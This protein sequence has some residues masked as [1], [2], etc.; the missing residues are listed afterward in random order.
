M[1]RMFLIVLATGVGLALTGLFYLGA[2]PPHP[3]ERH[4]VKVLPNSSFRAQ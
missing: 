1:I 4:V 3:V 2:F